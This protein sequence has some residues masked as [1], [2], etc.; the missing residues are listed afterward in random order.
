M[1]SRCSVC[2]IIVTYNRVDKLKYTMQR[3]LETSV[4]KILVIDNASTDLTSSYLSEVES[5]VPDRVE[6]LRLNENCGGAGGFHYGLA[7]AK[8]YL[9][10]DWLVLSDDDSYPAKDVFCRFTGVDGPYPGESQIVAAR[11]L[12][13][14]GEPCPMNRPMEVPNF[15]LIAK[16]FLLWRSLLASDD[17][18]GAAESRRPV[19][20][21][22][23]VG[24]FIPLKALRITEV[25]PAREYFLYWDDISFGLDMRSAGVGTLFCPDLVFYHDCPR[26]PGKM[27]G[28]RFYY[29]VRNGFRTIQLMPAV[30]RY[31]AYCLKAVTW[32]LQ[33]VRQGSIRS[34]MRALRDV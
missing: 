29:Y 25:M 6:V 2:A 16:N 32:L 15:S 22:S 19:L 7:Y 12:F 31:P 14:T 24:M 27:S 5:N 26:R 23:F 13:P 9:D 28:M 33:A 4:W 3:Y 1:S 21:S 18:L 30:I 11:V 20:A 10:C 17:S 34:Y 8:K